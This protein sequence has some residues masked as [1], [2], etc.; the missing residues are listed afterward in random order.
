MNI[1]TSQSDDLLKDISSNVP[2]ERL[3]QFMKSKDTTTSNDKEI[4]EVLNG[5][6]ARG[7]LSGINNKKPLINDWKVILQDVITQARIDEIKNIP[8]KR[9][10][11]YGINNPY[12]TKQWYL[13]RLAE[14]N[15]DKGE[16]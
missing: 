5:V 7:Q 16:K 6:Y 12:I 14:L 1:I 2:S 11:K 10:D 9:A 15:S 3:G 8:W 13:D 4:D